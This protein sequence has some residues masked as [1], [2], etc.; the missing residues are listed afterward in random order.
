MMA[1]VEQLAKAHARKLAQAVAQIVKEQMGHLG[2]HVAII[3]Q[4]AVK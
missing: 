1:A 3:V 2:A 4:Q